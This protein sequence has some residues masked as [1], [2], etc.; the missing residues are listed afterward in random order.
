[1]ET[2]ILAQST[3]V[4]NKFFS[5]EAI[6]RKYFLKFIL[7]LGPSIFLINLI[8]VKILNLISTSNQLI[9]LYLV[10]VIGLIVNIGTVS[11]F[12]YFAI[13]R[14]KDIYFINQEK[15]LT[16]WLMWAIFATLLLTPFISI[17]FIIMLSTKK[18]ILS[19]NASTRMTIK[20]HFSV[21]IMV[22]I[23][24]TTVLRL[25]LLRPEYFNTSIS[26]DCQSGFN[27][28]KIFKV[29]LYD[30]L[31]PTFKYI[32]NHYTDV[33]IMSSLKEKY[34]SS[35]VAAKDLPSPIN[36]SKEYLT[37]HTNRQF[38]L[39]GVLLGNIAAMMLAI[40][41]KKL[42]GSNDNAL[43]NA[44]LEI[45]ELGIDYG[46]FL[47]KRATPLS[48]STPYGSYL[49]TGSP[50][51]YILQIYDMKTALTFKK[52][53][54][55]KTSSLISLMQNK[56]TTNNKFNTNE[57]LPYKER[58]AILERKLNTLKNMPNVYLY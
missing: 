1:M 17:Y 3:L 8:I 31:T 33:I 49:I 37:L 14:L 6:S 38:S 29:A 47:Y 18:G 51:I 54:I 46:E 5:M 9:S 44:A 21:A 43:A 40:K 34:L 36:F 42:S 20:Q 30:N 7:I 52:T 56:L 45:I 55:E 25:T 48:I 13:R 11:F 10:M 28:E 39:T 24:L 41:K 12:V 58:L 16:Q 22:P 26:S 57:W 23:L 50:E 2:S 27:L 15:K 53:I 35:V 19:E 4:K 32:D